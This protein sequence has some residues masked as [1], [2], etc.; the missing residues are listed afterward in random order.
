MR[1]EGVNFKGIFCGKIRRYF[2]WENFLDLLKVPVGII[3]SFFIVAGFKP[4][5]VFCK[6]GYVS[7]PVAIGAFLARV[8]VVLHE[9][10][11]VP[12]L[13]NRLSARFATKICV[14]YENSKKFFPKD[15]V[16]LTGNPVRKDIV[17]GD[18][19]KGR[20][21]T[22]FN[23]DLPILLIMGGSQGAESV[24]RFIFDN[25][26]ELLSTFQII[27]ICGAGNTR[28]KN[29]LK[30]LVGQ[31]Y[32]SLL[33]RYV[34]YEFVGEDLKHFYALCDAV[35][36]R[37]GAMSLAEIAAI[38]KPAL[39]IPLGTEA[40]RGDQIDNAKAFAK[41]NNA[42]VINEADLTKLLFLERL[43]TV[44]KKTNTKSDNCSGD[45]TEKIITLLKKL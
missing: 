5:A 20:K 22:G 29:E 10:D 26:K 14:S 1:Q 15:K 34:S 19:E 2:S 30:H 40:S 33:K 41:E 4:K 18:A 35:I 13:A 21:N 7:F 43:E 3:Q 36:S 42:D 23:T 38:N 16:V 44:M 6:G 39:L 25:L 27:H 11:L 28:D 37:A 31:D 8:P 9:S 12:G 32:E 24:N 17:K 45:A